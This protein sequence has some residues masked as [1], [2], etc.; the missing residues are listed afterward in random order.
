MQP[1]FVA[2]EL[3]SP[4]DHITCKELLNAGSRTFLA[5]SLLL[6]R[7]VCA[8]A[9]SLYAFCRV[10]DDAIDESDDPTAALA[11]LRGRLDG[12][13]GGR[14]QDFAPDRAFADVAARYGIPQAVPDALLEGF[15]WDA[16]RRRYRDESDI[17]AYAV[18][19]AGTVGVMMALLMGVRDPAAIARAADLGIAM[20]FS[21]IARDVG[22]DAR[23][24]RL[25]LPI[26]WLEEEGVDIAAWLAAPRF[27]PAIA[28]CV[29]R[30]L[31]LAD[32]Y[33]RRAEDGIARLPAPCRP[34]IA[35]ARV[36][37]AEIG[38]EVE[39]QGLD[40]VSR[41]AVVSAWRKTAG[42]LRAL[43]LSGQARARPATPAATE[44]QFLVAAVA[45]SPA[46]S[47]LD[48]PRVNPIAA[49]DRRAAWVVD[50][51]GRLEDR[52]QMR[53]VLG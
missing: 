1:H 53:G 44:A 49:I 10:A 33:Y 45:N 14:P 48:R 37:Y 28:A 38:R 4:A 40:S 13:Y 23:A 41:R 21:N 43:A 30:L 7:E 42:L 34:G 11:G 20:Q 6:P 27:T 32:R 8:A 50:L 16:A 47:R 12:I 24:G 52:Q 36:L 3:A 31:T 51:F 35:A 22:E 15:A 9:V 39:R 46:P 17:T 18:R 5:A 26:A 25:Y 19:V 29:A 2:P